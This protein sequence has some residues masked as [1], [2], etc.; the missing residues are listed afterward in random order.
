M[1]S[2]RR[3]N[4]F[5]NSFVACCL[6]IASAA[7]ADDR[8]EYVLSANS[9]K[10]RVPSITL[11]MDAYIDLGIYL[12]MTTKNKNVTLASK[13][14]PKA[15]AALG[16]DGLTPAQR[17]QLKIQTVFDQDEAT[18]VG[19]YLTGKHEYMDDLRKL[20]IPQLSDLYVWK[21][22]KREKPTKDWIDLPNDIQVGFI[23]PND[24]ESRL[25]LEVDKR[26][27]GK[28]ILGIDVDCDKISEYVSDPKGIKTL[29][30]DK[31]KTLC[32]IPI[33]KTVKLEFLRSKDIRGEQL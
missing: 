6:L 33:L 32:R 28:I 19:I 5:T 25:F 18:E 8:C 20:L 14:K 16:L 2:Q 27:G 26:S 17:K 29:D 30:T 10:R 21:T 12:E 3:W 1:K 7:S 22:G 31:N 11:H 23:M 9:G 15:L 13:L 4:R 24:L